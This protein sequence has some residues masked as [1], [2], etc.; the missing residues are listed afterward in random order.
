MQYQGYF[1]IG[2]Q[3]TRQTF[4][5]DPSSR[6]SEKIERPMRGVS[7]PTQ[8]LCEYES[9]A[10]VLIPDAW[11]KSSDQRLEQLSAKIKS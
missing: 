7:L 9:D 5:D 1:A 8:R 11:D 2:H 4:S 6:S 3:Q 10:A